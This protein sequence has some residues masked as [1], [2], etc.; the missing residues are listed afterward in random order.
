MA[1]ASSLVAAVFRVFARIV[2]ATLGAVFAL[3]GLVLVLGAGLVGAAVALVLV[4]WARLRGR[5]A[6]SVRFQWRHAWARRGRFGTRHGAGAADG[7]FGRRP[8]QEVVD[9]EFTEPRRPGAE[10]P[11]RLE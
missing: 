8:E 5:P 11:R 6:G 10:P 3:A 2:V 7:A 9:V 4:A 1:R